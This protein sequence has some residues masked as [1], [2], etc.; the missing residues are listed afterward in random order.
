M[1]LSSLSKNLVLSLVSILFTG[2]L[3]SQS[4]E[5]KIDALISKQFKSNTTG[6]SV[7]VAKDGQPIYQKAFGLANVEEDKP[8]TTNHVFEIGSITKQFTA[9]AILMLEERGKLKVTDT[10]TKYIPDY[11]MGSQPI[12]IHHL[13]NH[14]SGIKSY[15]SIPTLRHIIKNETSTTDLIDFFKNQPTDFLP[16][17]KYKYNNSGYILLGYIIEVVSKQSY[18][19][20][21]EKEIFEKLNMTSS[22]YGHRSENITLRAKAYKQRNGEY[23]DADFIHM[24]IPYAAGALMSTTSDMLIWNEAL[25]NNKLISKSSYDKATNGSYLNDGKHIGYGYG[26]QKKTLNGSPSIE[27][28]GSIPGYKSMGVYLPEENVYAIALSNCGCKSP[29]LL[30]RKIAAIAIDKPFLEVEDA[31]SLNNEQLQKWT[32]AY[33]FDKK[34][35]RHVIAEGN[36][37]FIQKEGKGK[38][39]IFPL[40]E[41]TFFY[42]AGFPK[43]EF[44]TNEKGEKTINIINEGKNNIGTEIDK[45]PPTEKKEVTVDTA[46]LKQ[47]VG[48][49]QLAPNF[50]ITITLEDAKLFA[51][52]TNQSKFRLFAKNKNTF[53][54]KVVE[55]NVVFNSNEN[56]EVES[57]TLNQNGAHLGKKIK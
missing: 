10:I 57:L 39:R 1:H 9:V 44:S 29:T 12:T 15:T 41:N 11:P 53:F 51:Q 4:L 43:C 5:S 32:G 13:L 31:I 2:L 8:M 48:V 19:D 40:T 37:I 14:T 22:Y 25:I 7:L 52:A 18:E 27:H 16:G 49:Y 38:M 26:L 21:I 23:Q 17:E 20:F 36:K 28:G 45:A 34:V 6:L 55:A 30:T 50:T 56:N 54:L 24:S 3:F 46:I 42:K 33:E 35:V 47:Y